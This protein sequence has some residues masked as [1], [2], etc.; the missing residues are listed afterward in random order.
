MSQ[1]TEPWRLFIGGRA[2]A[3]RVEERKG[4]EK[5]VLMTSLEKLDSLKLR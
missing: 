2:K 4:N 5:E 3:E 1:Q